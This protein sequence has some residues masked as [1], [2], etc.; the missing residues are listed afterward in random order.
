MKKQDNPFGW[1]SKSATI[2][3]FVVQ[4]LLQWRVLV[5][6]TAIRSANFSN[7]CSVMDTHKFEPQDIYNIDETGCSTVQKPGS[8]V[9][10]RRVKQIVSVTSAERGQ[11]VTVINTINA[12]GSVL[13]PFFISPPRVNYRIISRSCKTASKTCGSWN[14]SRHS[15]SISLRSGQMESLMSIFDILFTFVNRSCVFVFLK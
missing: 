12:A 10:Q 9:A 8:V 14:F 5:L 6:S 2:L 4:K 11:S 13:P 7:F 1:A 3:P 15:L